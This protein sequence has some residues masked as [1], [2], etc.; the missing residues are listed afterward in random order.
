LGSLTLI[1]E[2]SGFYYYRMSKAAL[3]M[4]LRGLPV[5]VDGAVIP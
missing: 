5:N 1:S 4:G 3:D 2:M